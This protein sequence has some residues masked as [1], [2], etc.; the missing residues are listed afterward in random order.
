MQQHRAQHNF[1]TSPRMVT[2]TLLATIA[3]STAFAGQAL[4]AP[5]NGQPGVTPPS[6]TEPGQPGV[7][8]T[9]EPAPAPPAPEPTPQ[10]APETEPGF[11]PSPPQE[12][13]P[14]LWTAPEE[15]GPPSAPTPPP[16]LHA[17]TPE[18]P[19]A[20]KIVTDPGDNI[21]LG[22]FVAEVPTELNIPKS[23]VIS[24]NEY[25]AYTEAKLAQF[26]RSIGYSDKEADRQAATAVVAGFVGGVAAAVA[27]GVPTFLAV[28]LFTVPSGALIGLGI[29]SAIP[30]NGLN[31]LPGAAI[32]AGAGLGVAAATAL[33][34]AAAAGTLGAVAAAA[35]GWA[36]GGGNADSNP[37][38]PW[39]H[40]PEHA[41]I[42]PDANQF[43]LVL[44]APS[45][46]DA[47]L[48]A[49][50]YTVSTAGDVNFSA[51]IAGLPPISGGWTAE[52]AA[53]P[54]E[55]LGPL[56]EPA[57]NLAANVTKQIGDGLTQAVDG[58]NITYPQTVPGAAA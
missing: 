54:Y 14:I 4:G 58:L 12:A 53:A 22:D 30:P 15:Q 55:V 29:G 42:N 34:A 39:E 17:P 13:E 47:G 6:T 52:Q 48:P 2:A 56:A 16:Q 38:A 8:P 9:P 50:D 24:G 18:A 40:D 5:E 36:L 43:E 41:P 25:S 49:V 26:F 10:P 44:D 1:S 28:A 45:A 3:V 51:N 32:G 23:V 31:T 21:R 20:P 46:S 37:R 57:K 33:A 35:L 19:V 7:T 11:F 27:V